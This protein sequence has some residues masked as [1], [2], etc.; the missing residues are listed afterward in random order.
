[1]KFAIF[2]SLFAKDLLKVRRKPVAYIVNIAIPL[3][4]TGMIGFIFAPSEDGDNAM[5]IIKL[6]VVDEDKSVIGEFLSGAVNNEDMREHFDMRFLEREAAMESLLDNEIS[7]VLILPEGFTE[8]YLG[9]GQVPP[10]KL[11]KNPAQVFHPAVLEELMGVVVEGA[12]AIDRVAGEDLQDWKDVLEEEG[13]PNMTR[14]AGLVMRLGDRFDVAGEFLFPPLIQYETE[15]PEQAD[16]SEEEEQAF[17]LFAIILP[18]FM[19]LFMFFLADNVVRD[20][21]REELAKT[22]ERYRYFQGSLLPFLASKGLVSL[23][24]VVLSMYITIA[25]AILFYGVPLTNLLPLLLFVGTYGFFVTG[26][27]LF[28]NALAG[29]EKRADAVNPIFIFTLSFLGGNVLPANQLPSII[30]ENISFLLPNYWF[31]TGMQ[32]LQYG[33]YE[34]TPF[35]YSM[36][37]I[38]LGVLLF[39]L[40]SRILHS[41]LEG[42]RL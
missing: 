27:I 20:I 13:V 28:V 1:M 10:L 15:E 11:I 22:L 6:A 39:Y 26:F 23:I 37:M 31:I 16:G 36:L 34:V 3:L 21:Y 33:W 4:M 35:G 40:G 9:D 2:N 7:A 25:C 29:T 42:R 17:N 24:V 19:G 18:G 41:K 30:S 8:A 5:G 12:N 32:H 38:A 14:I